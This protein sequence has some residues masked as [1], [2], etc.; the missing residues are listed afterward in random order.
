MAVPGVTRDRIRLTGELT[1]SVLVNLS[2]GERGQDRQEG[3]Q[4]SGHH[5]DE[6]QPV[7]D[8]A[9]DDPRV[10]A[11]VVPIGKGELVCRKV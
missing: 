11:I 2:P 1:P 10:D 7:I 3:Q 4:S 9:T 5:R 8:R 6:L